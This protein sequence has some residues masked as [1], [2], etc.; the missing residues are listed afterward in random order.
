MKTAH[1]ALKPET[2][3][4][5]AKAIWGM[6][7]SVS[8]TALGRAWSRHQ[9][10]DSHTL[11]AKI[12]PATRRFPEPALALPLYDNNGKS[13]GLALISL[14]ASP[15]GRLTRGETRMVAMEG[16]RAA[17][18]Q[19]SQSGNTHV[20]NSVD[21]ALNVLR[22]HPG[23]GVVWQT[24]EEKLSSQLMKISR[25][26]E[27]RVELL[28]AQTVVTDVP[29]IRLPVEVPDDTDMKAL[30]AA[31]RKAAEIPDI[32][33]PVEV[34]DDTDMK[35]L[36]VASRK[37]AEAMGN[38][39]QHEQRDA[40]DANAQLQKIQAEKLTFTLPQEESVSLKPD[41]LKPPRASGTDT[42][43]S[44]TLRNIAASDSGVT[45]GLLSTRRTPEP[46]PDKSAGEQARA[47]RVAQDL[48]V[49]P[50]IRHP[51]VSERGRVMEHSEPGGH[52]RTIQKER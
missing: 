41:D 33:L 9:G 10:V 20:V 42:P 19:R 21:E 34:P 6:G 23:D 48:S 8:K 3:R 45:D 28:Q 36:L 14:V 4:Q 47:A 31:A 26:T 40:A 1:D 27:L 37:T 30:L 5:Q 22:T 46:L 7:Q 49:A 13:A 35:A 44:G 52:T 38:Q 50:D 11:T 2:Q 39:Q 32:R 16:A 15:E 24:G 12:I 25:G 18:L 17:V 51:D 29:D 43:D